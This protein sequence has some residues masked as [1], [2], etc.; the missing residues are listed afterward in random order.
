MEDIRYLREFAFKN[1]DMTY[2]TEDKSPVTFEKNRTQA[3]VF[4]ISDKYNMFHQI[5]LKS[6]SFFTALNKSEMVAV[7]DENL[8]NELFNNTMVVGM[9]VEIY[10]Q[11]FR[12][13]G[14]IDTDLSVVQTLTDNGFGSIFIPVEHKLAYAEN[15]KITSLEIRAS[16]MGTT[17]KNINRMNDALASIN[18]NASD[19]KIVD[20]NI[21]RVLLEEKSQI[22]IFISG[23]IIIGLLLLSIKKRILDIYDT[24]STAFKEKY[25]KDV[26]KQ[27][28][29]KLILLLLEIVAELTVIYFIWQAIKFTIYIPPEYIPDDLIDKAFYA[30]VFE[31]LINNKVLNA[32]YAPTLLEMKL[33]ILETMQ[34]W[35]LSAY[36]F[37]GFPLYYLALKLLELHKG[38]IIK[39]LLYSCIFIVISILLSLFIQFLFKMP[40]TVNAKGVV[41]VFTFIF[42]TVANTAQS[43]HGNNQK[44]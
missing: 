20:Y 6:G 32:G 9:Y 4:G 8:A 31:G 1:V 12:I 33:N 19:Y 26:I 28:Y 30:E 24:I 7:I 23:V 15:S 43:F 13:I 29:I 14:V 21:K 5:K 2:G 25:F 42:L 10:N 41:I 34:N 16:D 17:G 22:G 3:N 27:K 38:S 11:K 37:A 35:N 36:I 44:S 18:K 40:I 39:H